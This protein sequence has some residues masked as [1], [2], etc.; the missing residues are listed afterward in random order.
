MRTLA[1]ALVLLTAWLTTSARAQPGGDPAPAPEA[2]ADREAAASELVDQAALAYDQNQ[3]DQALQL[4]TRAY[5]LSPRPSILYNRAQVL[6]VQDD[7]AAALDAYRRFIDTTAPDDP[8]RERAL[9]RR[10]EMQACADQRSQSHPAAPVKLSLTQ[11]APPEP[12]SVVVS[13]PVTPPQPQANPRSHR[14]A[15]RVAGWASV[16]VGVVAAG[17]AAVLAWE[18][19]NIQDELNGELSKGGTWTMEQQLRYPSRYQEGSRDAHGAWWC[20]GVAAL[21]GA[22]GAALI[23]ISRPPSAGSQATLVGW[24]GSF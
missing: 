9:H 4:L 8:N 5:E 13:P 23:I 18:A 20:A 7:C 6:R 12:A 10:D 22:G 16:A 11:P 3:L 21:A 2:T 15:L 14:R 1:L 17:A 24:A 19:Q